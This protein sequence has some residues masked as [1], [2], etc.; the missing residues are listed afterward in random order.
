MNISEP[1]RHMISLG[2]DAVNVRPLMVLLLVRLVVNIVE[3]G[4][5]V[6]PLA[7]AADAGTEAHGVLRTIGFEISG[8]TFG[9]EIIIRI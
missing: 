7:L 8:D 1:A 9:K 6:A 3:M 4:Q 2:M 5:V